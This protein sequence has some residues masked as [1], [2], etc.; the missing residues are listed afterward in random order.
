V[1]RNKSKSVGT[2]YH[3]GV[4][5]AVGSHYGSG[6]E[7]DSGVENTAGPYHNVFGELDSR[8]DH[9]A[10]IDPRGAV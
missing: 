6:V 2:Q 1:G 8:G 10:G 4:E 3:V 9:G 7:D 5:D